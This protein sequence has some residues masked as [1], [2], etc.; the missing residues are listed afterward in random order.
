MAGMRKRLCA[1]VLGAA[2]LAVAFALAGCA[3]GAASPGSDGGSAAVAAS[4]SAAAAAPAA[5]VAAGSM[6]DMLAKYGITDPTS[7]VEKRVD[8]SLDK[9][10]TKAELADIYSQIEGIYAGS[11]TYD[12]VRE[13]IG[14]D[15]NKYRYYPDFEVRGLEWAAGDESAVYIGVSFG[16]YDGEWKFDAYSKTNM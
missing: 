14:C 8:L 7:A 11:M 13:L 4:S 5:A 12:E 16:I 6:D 10:K 9:P 1:A 15:P 3:G 2:M